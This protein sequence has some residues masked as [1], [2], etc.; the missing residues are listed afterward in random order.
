[1]GDILACNP[2]PNIRMFQQAEMRFERVFS[3]IS[4]TCVVMRLPLPRLGKHKKSILIIALGAIGSV[5][6]IYIYHIIVPTKIPP[7]TVVGY[8][9]RYDTRGHGRPCYDGPLGGGGR[10]AT[11]RAMIDLSDKLGGATDYGII[12]RASPVRPQDWKRRPVRHAS[13]Y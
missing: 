6:G 5:I 3:L 8:L 1:M 13:P 9:N 12:A 4:L 2:N 10:R 11:C 7:G